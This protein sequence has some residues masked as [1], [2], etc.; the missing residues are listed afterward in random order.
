MKRMR[1]APAL[2]LA[3]A[4]ALALACPLAS[5]AR[6]DNAMEASP[7][8]FTE[9]PATEEGY[10]YDDYD[11]Y[12]YEEDYAPEEAKSS[13]G[14]STSSTGLDLSSGSDASSALESQKLIYTASVTL[15]TTEYQKS[16]DELR[17][18][19]AE[20]GAFAEA[21][22]E[23]SY[24]SQE[25]HTLKA[26]LRVPAEN[27]DKLMEGMGGIEGTVTNRSAQVT[28]ITREY[29][30]NEAMIE[31]LEIQEKRLLEMME[32]AETIED[33][34]LVEER[35]SDVQTSLDIYRMHRESMDSDVSL[36]TVNVTISEVRFATTT[37][38]TSYLARVGNAF[39]D[40]W[41]S[42][43]EGL[44]DF[45]IGLIYA[46]PAIV[47]VIVVVLLIRRAIRK[48][49]KKTVRQFAATQTDTTEAPAS[50]D[51]TQ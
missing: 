16:V 27:Y 23:W 46:I 29:A 5:C 18:L 20:C 11:E 12:G 42:F 24:G 39:A 49:R 6:T 51:A 50:N 25:L 47:I 10:G 43:V 44:G 2:A 7:T 15:E 45:G 3:A 14:G 21:E 17:S 40:M 1:P 19:M 38:Q 28:N 9:A 8:M 33:M 22:D 41:D 4:L 30:D 26:T 35:L 34:I 31:G 48:L 36:S 32:Q 37:A 13:S